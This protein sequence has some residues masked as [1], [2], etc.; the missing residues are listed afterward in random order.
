MADF[1]RLALLLWT[2][3]DLAALSIAETYAVAAALSAS[4]SPSSASVL[5]FLANVFKRVFCER[6][7]SVRPIV[8]RWFFCADLV[9]AI[10]GP[11]IPSNS[12]CVKAFSRDKSHGQLEGRNRGGE[13]RFNG[14]AELSNV[15]LQ[16]R[17]SH[18]KA[19]DRPQTQCQPSAILI[20][21]K[22]SSSGADKPDSVGR[23][24]VPTF[25]YLS[26]NCETLSKKAR[27][28]RGMKNGPLCPLFCLASDWAC[29]ARPIARNG[30]GLLPHLFN[31]TSLHLAVSRCGN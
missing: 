17:V 25:I 21:P 14:T 26:R 5:T 9:F 28:T 22:S 18:I 3:F 2:S 31:L 13:I 20:P 12:S 10:G 19:E 1:V 6:L 27:H 24:S 16:A 15:A 7:R 30:G 11:D 8:L 29:H 23:R 4:L